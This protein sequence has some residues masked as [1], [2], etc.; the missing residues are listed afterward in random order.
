[1]RIELIEDRDPRRRHLEQELADRGVSLALPHRLAW[2]ESGLG[3]ASTFVAVKEEGDG[4]VAALVVARYA[5][6]ALPGHFIWRVE[7][8]AL[9]VPEDVRNFAF[10]ALVDLTRRDG[11][12]LRVIVELFDR[13]AGAR[14][15]NA[16][17]LATRG[18]QRSEVP[19]TY[20][21]TIVI[22]LDRPLDTVFSSFERSA[23]RN[24]R[25][26]AKNGLEVR[27]IQDT[28]YVPRLR[29][30]LRETMERTGGAAPHVD[31]DALIRFSVAEPSL[32]RLVG[33]FKVDD[34]T[35]D[36]LLAFAWGCNHGEYVNYDAAGSTRNTTVRAP[37]AYAL[38][39]DVISW[40]HGLGARWFDFGGVTRGQLGGDDPLG[41]ISDFKR[42][43]GDTV[44]PVAEDWSF[45]PSRMRS[46]VARA[47]GASVSFLTR[48]ARAKTRS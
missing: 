33:V 28:R 24:V 13:D 1:L 25:G 32:S 37:L 26:T 18:F 44:L 21:E 19:R 22:D 39:W 12:V 6:R 17:A 41:G 2:R 36:S 23:R 5:S 42:F 47:V 14:E 29:Q 4:C 43:F 8:L 15:R 48:V 10:D 46:A 34:P 31:W 3:V 16:R 20:G 30:L 35:D 7:R 40:A 45:E 38:A 11:R 27:A 9:R